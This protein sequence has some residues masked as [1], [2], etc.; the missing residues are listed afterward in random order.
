MAADGHGFRT[1]DGL[2]VDGKRVLVRVDL[3]VPMEDGAITD[4]SRI[5][6][7]APTVN[8]LAGRGAKVI[9][10]SHFGRPKG[11]R[12]EAMSLA[13]LIE[14]LERALKCG[15]IAF[16]ADC[17]GDEARR[18]VETLEP[19]EIALL[20]NLRFHAGEEAN[21]PAFAQALAELGELYVNDAFA[22]AHRGHASIVGLAR[23]LPAA[24]GRLM[25]RELDALARALEQP[26]RPVTAIVGGAKIST[27]LKLLGNLAAKV[28]FLVIG[29]GMANTLLAAGGVDVGRSL[30]DRELLEPAR[31]I[32][33][34][35][36]RTACA[37]LLP[38]DAVI[39]RDFKRGAASETVLIDAVPAD[40]MILDLGPRTVRGIRHRLE[41]SK[42]LVWNVPLGAF[43]IP[44]FDAAT[45]EVA[46]EAARLTR[47][48]ALLSVAGGG[49]TLAAL[50]QAG[51]AADF[52][53]LSSAG[54][55]FLEWLEGR[56]LPGVE[57]LREP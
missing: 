46:R 6:G 56:A 49:D 45:A 32:I 36:K 55:A 27:K 50:A 16:A 17:I 26:E 48:G 37:L 43:E 20:E 7:I 1:I 57:A 51:V 35:A 31:G 23:R 41:A 10:I 28:D 30:C 9:L 42:T 44:P 2:E 15:R 40:A 18:I 22:A 25:E 11:K 8:E 5:D 33:E 53:Y 14:P 24:A 3:N 4:A 52:S 29:G 54:G 39:A 12:V 47:E 13:P 34:R 19:G 38:V 21:D